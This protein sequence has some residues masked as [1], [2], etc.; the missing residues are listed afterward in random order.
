MI[1][2]L[3]S[4]PEAARQGLAAVRTAFLARD[5]SEDA[6]SSVQMVLAEAFN[7]VVEHAY[8]EVPG[9]WIEL[10][11]ALERVGSGWSARFDLYDQGR[12]M[13]DDELP[14]GLPAEVDVA[15]QDLPEGGFG[16]FLIR[17]LTQDLHY[18][19]SDGHNHLSFRMVL[20]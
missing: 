6:I 1:L 13:P 10:H 11:A 15:T 9:G 16:W 20:P 3:T 18:A 4:G 17:E 8:G 2:T 14:A 7:N 12:A 5:M 19:R